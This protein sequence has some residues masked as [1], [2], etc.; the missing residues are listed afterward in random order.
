MQTI[1]PKKGA[2]QLET[3]GIEDKH[4]RDRVAACGVGFV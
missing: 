4:L 3:Q 2:S 1:V